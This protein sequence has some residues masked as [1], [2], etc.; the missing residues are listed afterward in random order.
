M[1]E[2]R[3]LEE[4][5]ELA[6][7]MISP[8]SSWNLNFD[9]PLS[10]NEQRY[11]EAFWNHVH[12]L[13]PVVHRPSFNPYD[14]SPL[15]K[16]SMIALGAQSLGA[17]TDKTNARLIHEKCIKVL[18]KVSTDTGSIDAEGTQAILT[19]LSAHV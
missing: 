1:P 7:H 19:H 14:A 5:A 15:L 17:A 12:P 2:C 18:K 11:L 6:V 13:F 8:E 4:K 16:A 10:N 3:D 9:E